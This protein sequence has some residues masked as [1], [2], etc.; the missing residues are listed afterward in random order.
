MLEKKNATEVYK[1]GPRLRLCTFFRAAQHTSIV[2]H[3]C[4][5]RNSRILS[6]CAEATRFQERQAFV[7]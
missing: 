5:Q 7:H 1:S 6:E 3:D 4:D 2:L